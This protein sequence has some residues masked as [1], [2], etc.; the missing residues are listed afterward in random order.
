M[1]ANITQ[2]KRYALYICA[3]CIYIYI[4]TKIACNL[5]GRN[6]FQKINIIENHSNNNNDNK[7]ERLGC[8]FAQQ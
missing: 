3:K 1:M 2:I 4:A 5:E 7:K 8:V 6:I